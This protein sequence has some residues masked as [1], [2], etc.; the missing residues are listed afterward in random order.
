MYFPGME[1]LVG[2]GMGVLGNKA[3]DLYNRAVGQVMP[4]HNGDLQLAV[5]VAMSRAA[6]HL[7]AGEGQAEDAGAQAKRR[8]WKTLQSEAKDW[9][10][11]RPNDAT[12][13]IVTALVFADG[14]ELSAALDA[15]LNRADDLSQAESLRVPL[16]DGLED[17]ARKDVV[18]RLGVELAEMFREVIKEDP[19]NKGFKAFQR[20]LAQ[21]T[22]Q[23]VHGLAAFVS[24][25]SLQQQQQVA[26]IL[27]RLETIAKPNSE[28]PD[29]GAV[30]LIWR[31][32]CAWKRKQRAK[33]YAQ[34]R[35]K[36]ARL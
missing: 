25:L 23:E 22:Y 9:F 24:Q 15:L 21:A 29:A 33:W 36:R 1:T 20:D 8:V 2:V 31:I 27:Q 12:G 28:P 7:Y 30:F 17:A 13:A 35:S 19:H 14:Q 11:T 18:S 6:E 32:P 3:T 16:A 10:V 5:A 4:A 34:N 26:D